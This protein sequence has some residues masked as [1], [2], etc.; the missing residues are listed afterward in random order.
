MQICN[1]FRRKIS[2]YCIFGVIGCVGTVFL[3]AAQ[4]LK[5]FPV[6][7][8]HFSHSCFLLRIYFHFFLQKSKIFRNF[9]VQISY[10]QITYWYMPNNTLKYGEEV[11]ACKLLIISHIG[12][13]KSQLTHLRDAITAA[14][15]SI[16][17]S[18]RLFLCLLRPIS[19][20]LNR[21]FSFG[22]IACALALLVVGCHPAATVC[23]VPYD[24]KTPCCK[25]CIEN[26]FS[27]KLANVSFFL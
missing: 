2:I 27:K 4:S 10:P 6:F 21:R 14:Y 11:S 25:H 17:S 1:F 24:G 22:L 13:G 7:V 20:C 9:V 5:C 12:G 8:L 3:L 26:I 19:L 23:G 18:R 16:T 15:C